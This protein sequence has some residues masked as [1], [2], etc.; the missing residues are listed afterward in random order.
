MLGGASLRRQ[1]EA[2]VISDE[3]EQAAAILDDNAFHPATAVML[4][5][6]VLE[7][8]LRSWVEE[9][10]LPLAGDKR[11]IE[12]YADA[13]GKPGH[14]D[15]GERKDLTA[16]ADRRNDAAHGKFEKVDDRDRARIMVEGIDLFMRK[17]AR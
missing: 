2:D 17:H 1:A 5:G 16:W 6:A 11:S 12:I 10:G 8:Y 15:R 9:L 13:L 4:A 14:V 3:L 7:Q